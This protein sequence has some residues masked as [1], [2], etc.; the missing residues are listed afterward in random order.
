MFPKVVDELPG[1]NLSGGRLA[2][3]DTHHPLLVA[4]NHKLGPHILEEATGH[5]GVEGHGRP[6]GRRPELGGG[7]PGLVVDQGRGPEPGLVFAVAEPRQELDAALPVPGLEQKVQQE[8]GHGVVTTHCVQDTPRQRAGLGHRFGGLRLPEGVGETELVRRPE[9]RAVVDRRRRRS[10]R[11]AR[12]GISM[13][14]R[15]LGHG[16]DGGRPACAPKVD[17][18]GAGG[19]GAVLD[20]KVAAR[21]AREGPAR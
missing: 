8:G 4:H 13:K 3:Q 19:P 2:L 16:L 20:C 14:G 6:D 9:L 10:R 21:E 18:R 5:M 7:A 1:I 17:D 15:G 12:E 11:D